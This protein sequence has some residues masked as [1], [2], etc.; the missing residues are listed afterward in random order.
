MPE[1]GKAS[2]ESMCTFKQVWL[3]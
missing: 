1:L 2:V 3:E